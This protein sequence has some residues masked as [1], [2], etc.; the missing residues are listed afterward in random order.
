MFKFIT[1]RVRL[2]LFGVAI[3]LLGLWSPSKALRSVADSL[4]V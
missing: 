4:D 1:D 2:V 3:I